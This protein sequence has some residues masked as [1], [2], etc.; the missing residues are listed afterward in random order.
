MNDEEFLKDI[1]L[2]IEE[3][4]IRN[5]DIFI[6]TPGCEWFKEVITLY[7]KQHNLLESAIILTDNG[8]NEEAVILARSAM[9]NYFLIGYILNDDKHKSHLKEF[10]IQP[11]ISEKYL[12]DNMHK[13]IKG[14]F[15]KKDG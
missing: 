11:L 6:I 10:Q 7:A 5:N 14:E 4:L 12:V 13:M 3:Y 15:G 9:N 2:D 1:M 8:M